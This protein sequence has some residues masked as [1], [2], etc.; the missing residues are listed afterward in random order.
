VFDSAGE[1]AMNDAMIAAETQGEE[2]TEAHDFVEMGKVSEETK[3]G[4]AGNSFDG[5]PS[6][7]W[8]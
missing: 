7:R 3:G 8:N 2:R 5:V 6:G 1:L 4:F